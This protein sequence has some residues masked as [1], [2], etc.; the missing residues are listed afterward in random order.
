M[1]HDA[2]V[3]LSAFD[4]LPQSSPPIDRAID[5]G[6]NL[7]CAALPADLPSSSR[8]SA[9]IFLDLP[10]D[11]PPRSLGVN[12]DCGNLPDQAPGCRPAACKPVKKDAVKRGDAV[13][14]T[15]TRRSKALMKY[16]QATR[17]EIA[18]K[19]REINR[20]GTLLKK[21]CGLADAWDATHPLRHGNHV[22]R[23][24]GKKKGF[25]DKG[26][27][28]SVHP[29]QYTI[30]GVIKVGFQ[31]VGKSPVMKTGMDGT[32]HQGGM[33][34]VTASICAMLQDRQLKKK[35]SGDIK[36]LVIARHHDGTPINV[37]FGVLQDLLLP[38]ARY[39]HRSQDGSW[40]LLPWSEIRKF[41]KIALRSGVIELFAQQVECKY[42][43]GD[44][45]HCRHKAIATPLFLQAGNAST[46]HTALDRAFTAFSIDSLKVI[47]D[48]NKFI[49]VHE[50]PDN[51]AYNKRH[52]GYYAIMDLPKNIFYFP[53]GCRAHVIS[54]M[55]TTAFDE[56]TL[57]GEVYN[58]EFIAN[59]NSYHNR[60]LAT[61][62]ELL[63]DIV[64]LPRSSLDPVQ[65]Q[66]YNE[67]AVDVVKHTYS[68]GFSFV[69]ARLGEDQ[70]RGEAD[71]EEST[72][73]N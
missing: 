41:T 4:D 58:M 33:A 46:I 12:A 10:A 42:N 31:T 23:D 43:D 44:G 8:P 28:K 11:L 73:L 20:D 32:V 2:S 68:R 62:W 6:V 25:K 47:A 63:D 56:D 27:K 52:M 30:P 65:L 59:V 36:G 72:D 53:Y 9:S 61:A 64:I 45:Y 24:D 50:V 34:S 60:L 5:V 29:R 66:R 54:R 19:R 40:H 49:L 57:T 48:Q 15:W 55:G 70:G 39:A 38:C 26:K 18:S 13:T 16:V 67:H 69:R 7:A 1:L 3:F 21:F 14:R 37:A 71:R 35:L 22:R 51:I 17:R